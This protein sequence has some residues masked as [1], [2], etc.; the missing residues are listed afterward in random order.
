VEVEGI[1]MGCMLM[2]TS[3]FSKLEKPY[4]EFVYKDNS[5]HGEDFELQRK[6][7]EIGYKIYVDTVLSMDIKHIG[8]YGY[9][10]NFNGSN[11]E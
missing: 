1:G 3:V 9:G 2:K 5:W 10:V 7:R 8:L 6:L 4:F 11:N